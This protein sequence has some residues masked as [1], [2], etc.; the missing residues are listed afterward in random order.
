M[1]IT[2][3][4]GQSRTSARPASGGPTPG[5][6][7]ALD[8]RPDVHL[9]GDL[10]GSGD[11]SVDGEIDGSIVLP[12]HVLSL[13]E[14]ARVSAPITARRVHIAGQVVGDV[15]AT[16]V[17]V[18]EATG[19]VTGNIVAPTV[20]IADGARFT[21]SIDMRQNRATRAATVTR[22]TPRERISA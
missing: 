7:G 8:V 10:T 1:W 12:E 9:H 15:T 13:G 3:F 11:L 19:S 21:G 18:L 22:L 4:I 2:S 17:V 5:P 6:T 20:A 14:H 16:E